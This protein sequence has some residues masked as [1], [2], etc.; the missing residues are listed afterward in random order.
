MTI[1]V[2]PIGILQAGYGIFKATKNWWQNQRPIN[3]VLQGIGNNDRITRVFIRDMLIPLGTPLISTGV[4]GIGLVPNV[5][6]LWPRVE[7]V[8]M[9]NILNVLGQVGKTRNIEIIEM[10]KDPGLWD[11][12]L[13]VLG[14]QAQKCFDFYQRMRQ[15]A[16]SIDTE[17]RDASTGNVIPRQP[18]YGYGIIL[19]A[20]NP[21]ASN[22][23]GL[24]IGGYGVLGT[25]T[26]SYY[27]R[28]YCAELGQRFGKKFFGVVVRASVT[29]GV[30]S[31]ERLMSLDKSM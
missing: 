18:G 4:A 17:L 29:A 20:Q 16:Y 15:V 24:L 1:P 22:S 26:A 7:G 11:S 19:K 10:S 25:E 9:A 30:Q 2:D 27:F 13:I 28:R 14:A 23:V 6:E 8:A 3:Q 12:D 31:V 21:Y 5:N